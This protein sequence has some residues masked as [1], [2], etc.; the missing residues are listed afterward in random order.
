MDNRDAY[1]RLVEELGLH[2]S[3]V[4]TMVIGLLTIFPVSEST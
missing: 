2:K 1:V 3:V 4:A